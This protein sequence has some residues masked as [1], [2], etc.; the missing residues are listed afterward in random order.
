MLVFSGV[1][2]TQFFLWLGLYFEFISIF[3]C[4][5]PIYKFV[6]GFTSIRKSRVSTSLWKVVCGF[7]AWMPPSKSRFLGGSSSVFGFSVLFDFF[8]I[9]LK[10]IA[11]NKVFQG[12]IF[13]NTK[14]WIENDS[15][16]DITI[17]LEVFNIWILAWACLARGKMYRQNIASHWSFLY[18]AQKLHFH[19]PVF[20]LSFPSK[21]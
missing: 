2:F 7:L 5:F 12:N 16:I 1:T 11:K 20:V 17:Q 19:S 15:D 10:I 6:F 3:F 13:F 4:K 14:L 18:S 9:N 8:G 21:T